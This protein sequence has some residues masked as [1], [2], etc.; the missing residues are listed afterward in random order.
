[1]KKAIFLQG[2][3]MHNPILAEIGTIFTGLYPSVKAVTVKEGAKIMITGSDKALAML[4]QYI[5]NLG[6]EGRFIRVTTMQFEPEDDVALE[7]QP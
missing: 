7:D 5:T 4:E 6:E 2:V 3:R 1:M